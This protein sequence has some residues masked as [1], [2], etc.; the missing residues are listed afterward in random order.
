M[1][2]SVFLKIRIFQIH[3]PVYDKQQDVASK[4]KIN[5][6]LVPGVFPDA[7]LDIVLLDVIRFPPDFQ[8]F[9]IHTAI[10]NQNT[11]APR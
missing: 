3:K 6:R 8:T 4:Q 2:F 1:F 10:P 5:E 11:I 7:V 9:S